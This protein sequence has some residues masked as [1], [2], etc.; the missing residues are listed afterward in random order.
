MSEKTLGQ[1]AREAFHAKPM[2]HSGPDEDWERAAQAV[3]AEIVADVRSTES[4]AA[5][6]IVGALLKAEGAAE[7]RAEIL[8]WLSKEVRG[9]DCGYEEP[10]NMAIDS[11]AKGEHRAGGKP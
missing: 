8:A 5:F 6:A 7:E 9:W 4:K 11:I 3:V 1:V 2:R 10:L